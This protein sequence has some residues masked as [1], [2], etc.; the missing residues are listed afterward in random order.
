MI[1]KRIK[2]AIE[3]NAELHDQLLAAGL[4]HD[5]KKFNRTVFEFLARR[6][7]RKVSLRVAE[8][9]TLMVERLLL[10]KDQFQTLVDKHKLNSPEAITRYLSNLTRPFIWISGK[11]LHSYWNKGSAKE[12]KLNALLVYLDVPLTEWD[13]W[14]HGTV[15]LPQKTT[16]KPGNQT[17]IR[18][19]FLGSYFLYYRK[20]DNSGMLIKAPFV[21]EETDKGLQARTITEGHPYISNLIELREGV[22][23]IHLENQVFDDKENHIFNVGNETS[24]EVLFGISNTISVKTRLAIGIHN[25]LVKQK[26]S[27]T[28]TTF[29]EKEISLKSPSKLNPEENIVHEY[30]INN[31]TDLMLSQHCCPLSELAKQVGKKHQA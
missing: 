4:G 26:T 23:Y 18:K 20:T 12:T 9:P 3:S 5:W 14:K 7:N 11:T 6:I 13:D 2:E 21:L 17:L 1:P 25:V 8:K 29:V 10:G 16:K 28:L 19:Y 30:F 27:F 24:P 31:A 15:T 22:L